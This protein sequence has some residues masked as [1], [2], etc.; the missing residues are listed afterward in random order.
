MMMSIEGVME[1][2]E[3]NNGEGPEDNHEVDTNKL[4]TV[5]DLPEEQQ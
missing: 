3:E 1:E 2:E 4:T 5:E